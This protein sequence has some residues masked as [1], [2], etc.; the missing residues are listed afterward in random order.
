MGFVSGYAILHLPFFLC[1]PAGHQSVFWLAVVPRFP[2]WTTNG[3]IMYAIRLSV[4]PVAWI[5]G[6]VLLRLWEG[7]RASFW[8]CCLGSFNFHNLSRNICR[9]CR[10]FVL[11]QQ[12]APVWPPRIR[13]LIVRRRRRGRC[14]VRPSAINIDVLCGTR[15]ITRIT[16]VEHSGQPVGN[17]GI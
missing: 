12:R 10:N 6:F 17:L 14:I 5:F 13:M 2:W 8:R 16:S 9:A 4:R 7:E 15:E 1:F 3:L 11:Q